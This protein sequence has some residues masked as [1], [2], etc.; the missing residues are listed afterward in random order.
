MS[1]FDPTRI[2]GQSTLLIIQLP[3]VTTPTV[4]AA[5]IAAHLPAHSTART[6][7]TTG[8]AGAWAPAPGIVSVALRVEDRFPVLSVFD[9]E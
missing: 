8:T 6:P 1:S 2:T 4:A 9:P 7:A 5:A 3:I